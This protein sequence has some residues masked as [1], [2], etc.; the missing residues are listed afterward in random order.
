MPSR[1]H[2]PEAPEV[3]SPHAHRRR[4][5]DKQVDLGGAL[6]IDQRIDLCTTAISSMSRPSCSTA[7]VGHTFPGRALLLPSVIF[8][9]LQH[10]SHHLLLLATAVT[11]EHAV[12]CLGAAMLLPLLVLLTRSRSLGGRGTMTTT[13]TPNR[14]PQ[15]DESRPQ[16]HRHST[17]VVVA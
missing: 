15:H 16:R 13:S 1:Q 10:Q 5:G 8:S 11:A 2:R 4:G 6:L 14:L 17:I 9:Q 3:V 12:Q 7:C